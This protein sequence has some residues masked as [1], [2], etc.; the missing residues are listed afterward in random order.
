MYQVQIIPRADRQ[1]RIEHAL[2]ASKTNEKL[3]GYRPHP[4]DLPLISLDVSIPIYRMENFRTFTAQKRAI[5]K[6]S[7]PKDTFE[8]G[9]ES[10]STQQRQHEILIE[11]SKKGKAD[12]VVPI[13]DVLAREGQRESILITQFGVV[14]NGNRRLAAMRDLLDSNAGIDSDR[15][16]FVDCAV[17]PADVTA[18]DILRI[19]GLLQ[20]KAET[21]LDYDWI[22]NA[23]L[24]KSLVDL[25]GSNK[26]VAERQNL[27]VADVKNT[28]QALAE[29]DLYLKDWIGDPGAYECLPEDTEQL[30]SDLPKLLKGKDSSL[31]TASRAIAWSLMENRDLLPGRL[32]NYNRAIGGLSEGVLGR[33][34]EELDI[35]IKSKTEDSDDEGFEFELESEN[36]IPDYTGIVEILK[37]DDSKDDAIAALI[38]ACDSEI[39]KEK[40]KKSARAALNAVSQA[41]SKLASVDL[42]TAGSNTYAAME[43]QLL[44][45]KQQCEKLLTNIKDIIAKQPDE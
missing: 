2:E 30:F 13:Y 14:V 16:R 26:V 34:S 27:S 8:K 43:K 5:S 22:G 32:Y 9:Q 33:M 28:I 19:E 6:N 29:A 11:L 35:P 38:D 42:S 37:D 23:E 24:I 1:T 18:E 10:Q 31:Q 45:A 40:G 20:A 3:H 44:A 21:K 41:H 17:L 36:D 12:R 39:E 4:I 25:E 7:L 15:F